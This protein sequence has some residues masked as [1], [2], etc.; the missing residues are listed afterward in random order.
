[1]FIRSFFQLVIDLP[2][3]MDLCLHSHPVGSVT[4]LI[5]HALV[6][7]VQTA[8][9]S[10]KPVHY[11]NCDHVNNT[12]TK[13]EESRVSPMQLGDIADLEYVDFMSP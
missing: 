3:T 9:D 12:G 11:N 8:V 10:V 1:M 5:F 7:H 4:P 2:L 13:I 6:F